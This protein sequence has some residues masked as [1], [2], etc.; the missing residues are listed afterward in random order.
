MNKTFTWE[1][2]YENDVVVYLKNERTGSSTIRKCKFIGEVIGFTGTKVKIRQLSK[3]DQFVQP[4]ECADY[5]IVSVSP[6]DVV[7]ILC[8]RYQL[9]NWLAL[10]HTIGN[11]TFYSKEELIEWVVTAQEK[12][13]ELLEY[14]Y[15]YQDLTR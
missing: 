6:E 8:S 9:D 13:N 3:A 12:Y 11:I 2:I 15:M 4:E 14:K 10:P 5:G 1:P 7:H